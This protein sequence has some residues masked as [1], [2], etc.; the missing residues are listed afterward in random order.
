MDLSRR[1]LQTN[2]KLLK[3][4]KLVFELLTKKTKLFKRIARREYWSNCNVLY[5]RGVSELRMRIRIRGYP[6]EF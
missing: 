2:G 4:F 5:I 6:H 1:V 3:K